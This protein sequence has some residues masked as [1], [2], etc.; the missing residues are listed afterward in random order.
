MLSIKTN[1]MAENAARYLGE[2]YSQLSNSVQ[3][4]A[5][6][7]RINSSKDDAAGLAVRELLRADVAVIRQ[8]SRNAQDAISM[9]QAAEGAM[10]VIDDL[11]IRM[12][13]L[14]EQAATDTYSP[15]QRGIMNAEFTQLATEITRVAE[16][17]T[18]NS[19]ALLNS[20]S[21]FTFHVGSSTTIDLTAQPMTRTGLSLDSGAAEKATA[22][23]NTTVAS[24]IDTN[25]VTGDDGT[26]SV[27]FA[28]QEAIEITV[29]AATAY[30]MSDIATMIN[31]ASLAT[32]EAY[33]AA[34]ITY[35]AT[36]GK[37]SLVV[38]AK[39][40][41]AKASVTIGGTTTA[42][43]L[44]S[45]AVTTDVGADATTVAID[46]KANALNALS[47]VG[48]AI[49]TKDGYRAKLGYMMNRLQ[50][51]VA[52]LDIQAENLMSAE[53]RISDVDVASEMAQMTRLN[54]LAQAGISMLAQANTM[55]QMAL[56]LLR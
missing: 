8:G 21:T 7:L 18:F 11:L 10:S 26:F 5:S 56:Q 25:F 33:N 31:E 2:T 6:G 13:Q 4:L 37:Y 38:S 40:A 51:S 43:A 52:V 16:S 32:A 12:K 54:V 22:T 27:T 17:T 9:L 45:S 23:L 53:S 19:N 3:K 48:S 1:M 50:A 49:D 28:G 44:A 30:S 34:E 46:T 35:N 14:A 29:A 41:G 55:P 15:T 24:V 20:T 39:T 47:T 42:A 36:T